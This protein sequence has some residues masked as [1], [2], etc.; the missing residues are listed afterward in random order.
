[1]VLDRISYFSQCL[2]FSQCLHD[3][4]QH[5]EVVDVFA[6]ENVLEFLL[7]HFELVHHILCLVH[8]EVAVGDEAGGVF[9]FHHLLLQKVVFFLRD[10]LIAQLDFNA[11]LHC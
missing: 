5:L 3:A 2:P 8:F 1:M 9:L 7:K 11:E 10:R 6:F 4:V